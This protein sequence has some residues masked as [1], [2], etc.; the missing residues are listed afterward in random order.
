MQGGDNLDSKKGKWFNEIESNIS[1]ALVIIMLVILTQQV[2]M[3]YIVHRT[4]GWSGE[5]ARY[6]LIYFAYL[7]AAI[8]VSKKAHIK[9]DLVL[10][11]WPEALRPYLKLFSNIIF[12]IYCIVV[13][14]LS[15]RLAVEL[16]ASGSISLGLGIPMWFV[17]ASI[18]IGHLFMAIRLVQVEA[19]MIQDFEGLKESS[20]SKLKKDKAKTAGEIKKKDKKVGK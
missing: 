14:Y 10:N 11:L 12:F 2:F 7:T 5:A 20:E 18:P 6:L 8:A 1:V 16:Y 17:Y 13:A 9:V 4:Y 19:K 15:G 3:R